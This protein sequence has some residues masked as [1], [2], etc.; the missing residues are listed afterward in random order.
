MPVRIQLEGATSLMVDVSLDDWNKAFKK[1]LRSSSMLEIV[2]EDG[3]VL[4]IN[5]RQVQYLEAVPDGGRPV[6]EPHPEW[7][8]VGGSG[9]AVRA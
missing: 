4:A 8:P 7:E 2:S 6:S 3:R 9:G 5:P 1:A